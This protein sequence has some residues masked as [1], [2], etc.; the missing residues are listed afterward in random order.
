MF[1]FII[2]VGLFISTAYLLDLCF[3]DNRPHINYNTISEDKCCKI[4][5]LNSQFDCI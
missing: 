4:K 2:T 5:Q 1:K 3:N